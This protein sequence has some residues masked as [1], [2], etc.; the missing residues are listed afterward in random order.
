MASF[1]SSD[2]NGEGEMWVRKR[3]GRTCPV[4]FDKILER[5]RTLR[6]M[7]PTLTGV[8][9]T[10]VAQRVSGSVYAG[11]TTCEL[12]DVSA[13]I[14]SSM[15]VEHKDYAHLAGRIAIS[16][17]HKNTMHCSRFSEVTERLAALAAVGA[18]PLFRKD[19]LHIVRENAKFL[20]D[21]VQDQRDYAFSYFGICTLV[22]SYLLTHAAEL[23]ALS[24][25]AALAD[26]TAAESS[27]LQAAINS[28]AED[29]RRFVQ[30]LPA[31]CR[32]M[33]RPQHLFL[34]VAVGLF[35][36]NMAEVSRV[37]REL[38]ERCYVHATPTLFNA[39]L[40]S[41]QLA[42]CF[43]LGAVPDSLSGICDNL[44]QCAMISKSA[45]GIGINVHSVRGQGAYI[46]GTGGT[47]NGIV[48]MLRVYND[49]ARYVDQ[50]GGKR[51][52][53]IAV[54][55]ETWHPDIENF[56]MLKKNHGE[57][58][59]RARDLFYALWV[60][61]LFMER[62]KKDEHWTLLEPSVNPGLEDLHGRA[63]EERYLFYEQRGF[64][65]K[66]V[67]AQSIWKTALELQMETGTPYILYKD[68]CNA[69]SNQQN[70]GTIRSSN[71]CSE[72]IEYSDSEETA[73]CNLSSISLPG[74][75]RPR[76]SFA[77]CR[78]VI[79][80]SRDGCMYCA[81]AV[82][83]L[84]R[85]IVEDGAVDCCTVQHCKYDTDEQRSH[86]RTHVFPALCS[87]PDQ[88]RE[89]QEAE[90]TITFPQIVVDGVLVGG[91]DALLAEFNMEIDHARLADIASSVTRNLNRTIDVT[92][93]PTP[94]AQRSNQRHRPIGIGVQG[95]ADVFFKMRIAF[96]SDEARKINSDI[97]ESIYYGAMRESIKLAA[98]RTVALNTLTT[99]V[100][101]RARELG[102]KRL[103][104]GGRVIF[105]SEVWQFIADT[106]EKGTELQKCACQALDLLDE[107]QWK[108][109][110]DWDQPS[111]AYSSYQGSPLSRGL[112]Q[113]DMWEEERRGERRRSPE[114]AA[115]AL[116]LS[117]GASAPPMSGR[118]DWEALRAELMQHGA[119]NS[120]LVAPMP[121][122]TTAQ[123]LGNNECFEPVTSNVY[124]RRTLAG[125]FYVVNEYLM[126][127]LVSLG[128][129]TPA[130]KDEL[131]KNDGSVSN[132]PG[133][134]T[135]I[136]NLYKTV[137]EIS[138]RVLIDYSA[139]RGRFVCQSQSLNLYLATPTFN[140]LSSM[141][142]YGY[143]RG[144]KT[145]MY[146]L[147]T[148][149][150]SAAHKFT[151]AAPA[152]SR[153]VEECLNCS[154]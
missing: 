23:N 145:G 7:A 86:F 31:G 119:R 88:R 132:M 27:E 103:L 100:F 102:A 61:D 127:D 114:T 130:I 13:K 124:L 112:F 81:L 47:S 115:E 150:V 109:G 66:R 93:Y 98:R 35:G 64:G 146:Y 113:F 16:N 138:Q 1:V 63:F 19:Y 77:D 133:I 143:H 32:L 131:R 54:Y 111:G 38:S 79:V 142:F 12:D 154:A 14:C 9:V 51:K 11:V 34:R 129:W 56:L 71:L 43:L 8:N 106:E 69:K 92:T 22:R 101:P 144:L 48:P 123:I 84:E 33:E 136:K 28:A 83:M 29:A 137:W 46:S 151:L 149:P 90:Q 24:P 139:D 58:N 117:R 49:M 59:M 126:Q 95:L 68:A 148:R 134:P 78:S 57:E 39:G 116:D 41:G 20:D 91:Y 45:G 65:A 94:Q 105:D 147:H 87:Q 140:Q 120:L 80:H 108:E 85:R 10:H 53:S 36:R 107:I 2:S 74:A 55:L 70:L 73:V 62:V 67:S 40:Q 97:F 72:I 118:W 52:G 18:A 110:V 75:L 128:L 135:F 153:Q 37:Y 25:P 82:S 4:S 125:E 50:G 96:D 44:T 76:R 17:L 104:S 3:D 30:A 6:N 152:Q 42:S 99:E 26:D 122:A 141:H 121:T 15:A 89:E 5:L 60:P 21:L